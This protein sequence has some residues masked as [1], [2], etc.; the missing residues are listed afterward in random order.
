MQLCDKSIYKALNEGRLVFL[1]LNEKYP[2]EPTK[3]VQPASIDLRLGNRF[4]RFSEEMS[5]FDI[6]NIDEIDKY[7]IVEQVEDGKGIV[8]KPNEVIYGQIYEQISIGDEFS[9]KIEGRSRVARLGISVH[10]T[11]DYINPGF[12]GAMP[13]QIVNHNTFSITLYPYIGICQIIIFEL[14]DVP[15]VRYSEKARLQ[16]NRYYNEDVPSSSI[17]SADPLDGMKTNNTIIERKIDTIIKNY[18]EKINTYSTLEKNI[19]NDKAEVLCEN[20]FKNTII[21]G[22]VMRDQYNAKQA[23]IQGNNSGKNATIHQ[24]YIENRIDELE[25]E[26]LINEISDLRNYIKECNDFNDDRIDIMV[27]ELAQ[28]KNA[29]QEH[30]ENKF[31][32]LLKKSGKEF[33]DIAK[34]IGCSVVAKYISSQL[35]F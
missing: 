28:I 15:L 1:G 8:I 31:F 11:G 17:I 18:N 20:Y 14:K 27:G 13:L 3:Q 35:G 12:I 30:D 29:L 21:R 5:E 25:Y 2:F 34:S 16:N 4:E 6:R 23:G 9:A 19:N 33:Y 26:K 22:G 10:C 32:N 24:H 7:L